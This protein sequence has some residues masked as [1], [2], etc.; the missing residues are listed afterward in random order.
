MNVSKRILHVR[1]NRNY[2]M[3]LKFARNLILSI[4]VFLYFADCFCQTSVMSYNIRY[5]N[6]EDGKNS[7]ENRKLEVVKMIKYYHPGI[8]G[9][10]EGL[11]NQ[12]NYLDSTLN[13]YNFVGVGR[14]DGKRKG[15]FSAIF[16][17]TTKYKL[18]ET[19]TFWLS[20]TPNEVSVGWDASMERICTYGAFRSRI[21]EDSIFVFNCHF[22]HRGKKSREESAHLV[23]EQIKNKSIGYSQIL[24]MG[25][26]NCLPHESPIKIFNTEFEDSYRVSQSNPYGPIGT[27]N[28]FNTENE[29]TDRIDY[30]I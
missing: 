30:I 25:D 14:D 13:N 3:N 15:E 28:S 10:Q 17:D 23:L 12:V 6:S 2:K 26:L 16:Y 24:V 1:L 9:I 5:N 7:W 11:Y 19:T 18:I 22:D 21:T 27:Y 8:L 20:P 29:L 4:V